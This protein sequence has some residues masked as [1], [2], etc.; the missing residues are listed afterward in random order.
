[1]QQ[2]EFNVTGEP[3][4]TGSGLQYIE[5]E[6]GTGSEAAAGQTVN[7]HYTGWLTDGR[8][9]DSSRDRGEPFS[10]RLG[11]G[12]VIRGWDEGVAGMRIG[13]RRRLI[14]P[15]DLGYGSRGVGPIPP[16]A[17]LLFN[18]ELLGAG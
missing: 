12:Q 6:A 2:D 17:T 4:N 13:G 1:M 18:V 3:V 14:I 15:A 10:F 11:G 16:G 5:M 7:V 9:F 8:K